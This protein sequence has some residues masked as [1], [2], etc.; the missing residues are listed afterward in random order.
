MADRGEPLCTT[1]SLY[2]IMGY[3]TRDKNVYGGWFNSH[4]SNTTA[5]RAPI[6]YQQKYILPPPP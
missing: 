4:F 5:P 2:N 1:I 6:F 3:V